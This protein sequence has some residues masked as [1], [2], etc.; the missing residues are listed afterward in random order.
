MLWADFS[1]GSRAARRSSTSPLETLRL[2]TRDENP[3]HGFD[4]TYSN[5]S[6]LI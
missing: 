4:F 6:D 1:G 2:L 3:S 5:I